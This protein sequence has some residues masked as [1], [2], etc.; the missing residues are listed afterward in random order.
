MRTTA[1]ILFAIAATGCMQMGSPRQ[2]TGSGSDRASDCDES[3][4]TS[5]SMDMTVS[6][7]SD[8]KSIPSSCWTMDGTLTI[9]SSATTLNKL[10]DLRSV[11]N[12][13]IKGSNLTEI[14]TPEVLT[15]T[16]SIDI[17]N[18]QKLTSLA[19]VKVPA[20][21]CVTKLDGVTI[22]A[23]PVLADL[24]GIQNL[25]CA[26]EAVTISN[27][28]S[29]T[30]IK[31]D[32]AQRFEGGLEISDNTH[33]TTLSL[34]SLDSITHDLIIKNNQNLATFATLAGLQYMHGS[35]EID[36]NPA[37]T[38]LPTEMQDPGPVVEVS[39]LITN[40][41]KLTNLGAFKKLGGVNGAMTITGNAQLDYCEAREVACCVG[42]NGVAS[43]STGNKTKTCSTQ[44]ASCYAA[45][46][47]ACL[48]QYTTN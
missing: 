22:S 43:I 28:V 27:N 6:D 15:V 37:L 17:E 47:N 42:H 35:I 41:A 33:L 1:S 32:M 48:G 2:G 12:L 13:V 23:N 8:L 34:S 5:K 30:Q 10:G 14:D 39:L 44:H 24:G 3:N 29:L 11:K 9:A 38:T 40:N 4:I 31:F 19:N 36:S 16:G 25:E 26:A 46:G 18:A 21:D 20:D 45:N 7:A